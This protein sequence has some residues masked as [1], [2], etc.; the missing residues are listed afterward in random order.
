MM[1]GVASPQ[2]LIDLQKMESWLLPFSSQTVPIHLHNPSDPIH[3]NGFE[4]VLEL[5]LLANNGVPIQIGL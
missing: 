1:G 2:A 4:L 3:T 5:Y